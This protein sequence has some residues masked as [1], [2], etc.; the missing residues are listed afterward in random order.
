MSNGLSCDLG[1]RKPP[2][3][4]VCVCVPE[5]ITSLLHTFLT[6]WY[7]SLA[8]LRACEEKKKTVI[9]LAAVLVY[10]ELDCEFIECVKVIMTMQALVKPQCFWQEKK[11]NLVLLSSTYLT[12]RYLNMLR[13]ILPK[14]TFKLGRCCFSMYLF[15]Y[16]LKMNMFYG[17]NTR[18]CTWKYTK[19][20]WTCIY[21]C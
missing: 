5:S 17:G 12:H 15:Y 21:A 2:F 3:V 4:C 13:E 18:R 11:I 14:C 1:L 16:A 10:H 7:H 9:A 8:L 6:C 19:T 20:A